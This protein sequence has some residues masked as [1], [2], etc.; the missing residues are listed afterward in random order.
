MMK[1][2][3]FFSFSLIVVNLF[4]PPFSFLPRH[5]ISLCLSVCAVRP[6]VS[7]PHAELVVVLGEE[8]TFECQASGDPAPKLVWRRLDA[9]TR[10]APFPAKADDNNRSIFKVYLR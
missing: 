7:V 5:F 2:D 6:Q 10:D 9:S 4:P 3:I 1:P 8:A